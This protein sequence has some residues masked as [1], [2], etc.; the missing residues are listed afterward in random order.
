VHRVLPVKEVSELDIVNDAV[1]VW[2]TVVE[3]QSQLIIAD[4][5]V[6]LTTRLV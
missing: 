4:W 2:I 5:H 6:E 3:Q 1:P